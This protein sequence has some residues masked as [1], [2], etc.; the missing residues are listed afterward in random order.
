M[1]RDRCRVSGVREKKQR[2]PELN[3]ETLASVISDLSFRLPPS[4]RVPSFGLQ[5]DEGRTAQGIRL[6][7]VED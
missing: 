3:T 4:G 1:A 2:S 6:K 5:I 7:A